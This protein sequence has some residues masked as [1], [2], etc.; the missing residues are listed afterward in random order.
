MKHT[1]ADIVSKYFEDTYGPAFE[2]AFA[3]KVNA[4]MNDKAQLITVNDDA[5]TSFKAG[6]AA[7]GE[8]AEFHGVQVIVRAEDQRKTSRYG[9]RLM[10]GVDAMPSPADPATVTLLDPEDG[11][12]EV[13]YSLQNI[14]RV[15]GVS[16]FANPDDGLWNYVFLAR[17]SIKS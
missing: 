1:A 4:A 12:T 8:V 2:D 16:V 6:R 7:D 9:N 14:S 10:Q 11:I 17:I 3:F 13:T 5:S 15:S